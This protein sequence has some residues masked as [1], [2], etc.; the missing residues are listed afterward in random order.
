MLRL[1]EPLHATCI[2]QEYWWTPRGCS[3]WT[4]GIT[5]YITGG[6]LWMVPLGAG[7]GGMRVAAA[8]WPSG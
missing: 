2:T 7:E 4:F 8:N 1:A 6:I 3:T 5:T